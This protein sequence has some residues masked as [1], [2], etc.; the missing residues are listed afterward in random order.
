MVTFVHDNIE[1]GVCFRNRSIW[2]RADLLF[3]PELSPVGHGWTS[4]CEADLVWE[5]QHRDQGF[6]MFRYFGDADYFDAPPAWE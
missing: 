2:P 5:K 6:G 3:H 1:K 4:Y